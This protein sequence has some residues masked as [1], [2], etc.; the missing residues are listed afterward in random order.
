MDTELFTK[1]NADK[2]VKGVIETMGLKTGTPEIDGDCLTYRLLT[3]EGATIG[4]WTLH[5]SLFG[6]RKEQMEEVVKRQLASRFN[7]AAKELSVREG[8]RA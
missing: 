1:K 2:L 4:S 5:A 8:N 7:A 6:Q 3:P